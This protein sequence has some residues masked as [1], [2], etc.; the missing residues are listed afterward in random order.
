M[1][2]ILGIDDAGRGP[3]IGPMI[4]AGVLLDN[5][6]E[7]I[8]KRSGATDS[9]LLHHST[10]IK[11]A[12]EIRKN[13][14]SHKIS[15]TFPEEIDKTL[16]SPDTNLNKLEAQ[17]AAEI[18]NS[19]NSGKHT[20]ERIQVI[21][22]CPSSNSPVW[23]KTLLKYIEIKTN[24]TV[25]CEHKADLNHISVAAASILAKVTREEE[26]EKIRKQ[27]GDIGSG[28]PSDP[29]TKEFLKQ[30]GKELANSG[31]F[32]KTWSTWKRLFPEKKQ[33]TLGDF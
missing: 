12:K 4:L 23:K 26:V 3:L 1:T 30:H 19:L 2:L 15:K 20:K 14:I 29:V 27:H 24:L 33:K 22:D 16:N 10:R 17:K 25:K 6:Q 32:R 11:I 8:I 31:I 5:N 9:K 7:K 13:S 21:V 28:Y 18:I